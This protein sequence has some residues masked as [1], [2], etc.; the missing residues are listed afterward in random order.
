[1]MTKCY[2]KLITF[3]NFDDRIEYLKLRGV[4]GVSTFGHNRFLNQEFYKTP[5]WR[6]TR[7]EIIIRDEGCDLGLEG[8]DIYDMILVHHINPIT[9]DNILND[10]E[11]LYDP[12]NLICS[13]KST[14]DY[15]HYGRVK[16]SNT[17]IPRSRN[18]TTPWLT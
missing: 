7:D 8:Y 11:C 3:D 12:E 15:M 4:V 16:R 14:H 17:I 2:S 6:N 10:D 13:S 18:D 5:K 9:I 1:M